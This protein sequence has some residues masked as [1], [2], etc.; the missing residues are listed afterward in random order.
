MSKLVDKLRGISES[1][2][3]P[4]GFRSSASESKGAAMLLVAGISD[5]NVTAAEVMANAGVDAGLILEEG[6]GSDDLAQMVK[7]MGDIPLG[8]FLG[9]ASKGGVEGV[10]ASGCDFVVFD[11]K[12]PMAALEEGD[13]GRFLAIEP[14]LDVGLVRA[15][16]GLEVD[17][18]VINRAKESFISVEYL[19]LCQRLGDVLD[20][21][22]LAALPSLTTNEELNSLWEAGIDGIVAP[23]GQ[24]SEQLLKLKQMINGLPTGTKRHRGKAG[25]I[26]PHYGGS[27]STE[28]EEEEEEEEEV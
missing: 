21:P 10:A 5:A 20:K 28:E 14:S 23:P 27:L 2:T 11:V 19:L 7:A 15:I 16:N 1:S 22:L 9:E 26:V 12:A 8:L 18:V 3:R 4:I 6:I 24:G 13:M 17:G 25:V